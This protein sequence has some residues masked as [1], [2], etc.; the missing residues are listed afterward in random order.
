MRLRICQNFNRFALLI[1]QM[2]QCG[3]L[4]AVIFLSIGVTVFFSCI[5]RALHHRIKLHTGSCHR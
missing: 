5:R 2:A 4:I 1:E 3:I